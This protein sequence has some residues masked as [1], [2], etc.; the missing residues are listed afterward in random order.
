MSD[1]KKTPDACSAD[2][3]SRAGEHTTHAPSGAGRDRQRDTR[4]GGER[5]A[6]CSA[7]AQSTPPF[8]PGEEVICGD[9]DDAYLGRLTRVYRA[10]DEWRVEGH[11]AGPMG[12][13]TTFGGGARFYRRAGSTARTPEAQTKRNMLPAIV[14][15]ALRWREWAWDD[16]PRSPGWDAKQEL[17]RLLEEHTPSGEKA[18]PTSP[19][20][21]GDGD[22]LDPD[23]R[24]A[25]Y[26]WDEL[27]AVRAE[28]AAVTFEECAKLCDDYADAITNNRKD[29]DVRDEVRVARACAVL[30]RG[31]A[32][33]RAV[34]AR[35]E[36][37]TVKKEGTDR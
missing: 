15:A 3:D 34:K 5:P 35:P 13:L 27:M 6:L 20:V 18:R 4:D 21:D 37:A 28:A 11:R 19:K 23:A 10:G 36:Q 1:E 9:A 33:E 26:S 14:A 24:D 12:D 32:K 16:Y 30:I 29:E 25:S 22:E 2:A 31:L 7:V 8:E 17:A